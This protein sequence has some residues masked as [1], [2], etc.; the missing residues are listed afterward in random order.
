MKSI[1]ILLYF[2]FFIFHFS[3]CSYIHAQKIFTL[4]SAISIALKTNYNI[5]LAQNAFK[6]SANNYAPGVAGMLPNI[7]ANASYTASVGGINQEF[8]TGPNITKSGAVTITLTP[9]VGLNWTLFD[10]TKMFVAYNQLGLLKD[11]GME[12]LRATIQDNVASVI[13]A[14][15]NMVQQKQLLA[16][17]D[18]NLAVFK[19]EMDI[20]QK[21]YEVGTGS[22]LN[23]LQ[24]EVSY[25]AQSSAY[26]K[27]EVN[28]QNA[29]ISL[30]QLLEIPVETTYDVR[31]DIDMGKE[32]KFDS[33]NNLAFTQNP[34]IA[35]AKTGIRVAE[36]NVKETNT[37]R[38]PTINLGLDYGLSR[39][40]S[41]A[42]FELYNQSTGLIQGGLTL[43]WT[44]FNGSII[45]I[46]H[47]NAQLAEESAKFQY[48]LTNIQINA[49]LLET[50]KEYEVNLKILKMDEENYTIAKENVYVALEQFRIGTT[51]IVQLQQAQASYASAGSQV[52]SDRYSFKVSETQLL[53][54]AGEL[55]K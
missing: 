1:K 15:Y 17:D 43:S 21:Q 6:T 31:N 50:F 36:N 11:E 41:N 40:N 7:S 29:I 25:N 37:M 23:Y 48:D 42:G 55:V 4:D 20:A 16:V 54:L 47:E 33:L 14:Y 10:G 19:V 44:I 13:E 34:S 49:T 5:L 2:L 46:Q 8:S 52:V 39:T 27:Q 35:L 26:L 18:S 38:L 53:Q 32:L 51:N 45:N 24:A 28:V 22:K 9:Y 3:F 12:N 30:N